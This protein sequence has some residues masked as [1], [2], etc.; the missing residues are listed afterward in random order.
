MII[1]QLTR[2]GGRWFSWWRVLP[3]QK[4]W[5][6]A[7]LAGL[8]LS[9]AFPPVS[10]PWGIWIGF[11]LLWELS[12]R[13]RAY[14]SLYTALLL[15][16]LGGCY[17]LML[18]ALSAPNFSEAVI[19]FAAGAAAILANP[20]LMLGVFAL[21]RWVSQRLAL[22]DVS[23]A[24]W[25]F[26]PLWGLFEYLHFRWELSW[27]WL[28][29]GFAWSEW[30][31]WRSLSGAFGV[32]GISVWTLI[33]SVLLYERRMIPFLSWGFLLPG[34]MV[35]LP[36]SSPS[37]SRAVYAIQPNIDPYVKFADFSPDSQ[38]NRLA[39]LL[40]SDPSQGALI[41]LP[42]TAIPAGI[43]LDHWRDDPFMQPFL[44]YVAQHKVNLLL[45][46][47]GYKY[48]PPG[49]TFSPSARPL[50]EGGSYETYNAAI[51]LRP[52]TFQIHIKSRLVPF[53]E[54]APFL[55][56]FSFLR[57]WHIDLGGGFGH[58]GKPQTQP[59]LTLYPDEMPVAVAICYES[60]FT[61]DLRQR[62]PERP[63]LLAILTNDGWWKKSSGF[64]QHLTYGQLTASALGVPAV[65][66]AN[67]GVSAIISRDGTRIVSLAYEQMG[68][69]ESTI[70]PQK[71]ATLY[72][73]FGDIGWL[74]LS[75][76]A[77]IIWWIRWYRSRRFFTLSER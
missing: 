31:Y 39:S 19:S 13:R 25:L 65:R 34:M 5:H 6:S 67:T 63:A 2:L 68:R 14:Y 8:L 58:F 37:T 41:V 45:G 48:F 62:L 15:W 29:L 33:G 56:M 10:L 1:T 76:F 61:H 60:I 46:V 3:I 11:P 69:V 35:L 32:V 64:W 30:S 36:H 22:S 9:L 23:Q 70:S 7:I 28:T 53:V 20:L 57:R 42:E 73:R 18:T 40:P 27:S 44:R 71:P 4:P 75:T 50:P 77:L 54:R 51:L 43:S 12:L 38:V 55:D 17:W 26:I 52:D 16:N 24:S 47:V 21:W 49:S 74:G 59:P 66:S 72:Y